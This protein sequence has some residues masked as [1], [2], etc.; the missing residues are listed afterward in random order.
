M[1]MLLVLSLTW[2]GNLSG[3]ASFFET[4]AFANGWAQGD[5]VEQLWP[6]CIRSIFIIFCTIV[7]G[8]YLFKVFCAAASITSECEQLM[9]RCHEL[10]GSLARHS[11]ELQNECLRFYD[12]IKRAQLGFTA[13]G[14]SVTY[15]VGV[16][17][18]YLALT[19]TGVGTSS[20][21]ATV[22]IFQ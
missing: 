6:P 1:V 21:A 7:N 18:L 13:L 14:M 3:L 15:K 11:P 9:D 4:K 19:L 10:H 17:F 16:K 5:G 20:I 22:Q 12:H 8:W 2:P